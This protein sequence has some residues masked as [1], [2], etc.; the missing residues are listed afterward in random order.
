MIPTQNT[1]TPFRTIRHQVDFCVV[2]GGLSGLCA[3]VAAARHGVRVLLMQDR[4]ML[5]GNASSEIRMWVCGAQGENRQETGLVEE[6]MLENLYRNPDRNYSVWDSVLYELAFCQERLTLLLNCSCMD[7]KTQNGRILSVTGWQMTTQT[8]HTVEA[9]IF[10]DCSGDSVLAP[11]SG[12][13]YRCGREAAGEFGEDIAPVLA[14]GKTMGMSC[15]IQAREETRPSVFIPPKWAYQ[16]TKEDL[17]YRVPDMDE[18]N[19][20]FWYMELGGEDDAIADT[21]RVRDEL[22]KVAYGVWDYVKNAPE[23]RERNSNWRL[24]WVGMLPGKRESRRYVGDHILTQNDV[25]AGGRFEDLVAYGGWSMDDHDPAGIRS[26]GVPTVFH[27]APSPYGIPYRC[28]YSQNVENLMFAGRNISVTHTAMSSTRVMATCAL[29]GQA[30]GTAAAIAV[31]ERLTPRGVYEKRIGELQRQLM[32]DDCW[33]PGFVREIPA[34]TK[35]A[36]LVCSA[37]DARNLRSGIDRPVG[38]DENSAAVAKGEAIT[39]RFSE[40]AAV[41]RVRVVFNSDLNRST[42]PPQ[43]ARRHRNMLHNRPLNWPDVYVPKTLVR[44]FRIEGVEPDGT[45]R[46]LAEET[47]NYRRLRCY[48]VS[49]VFSAVRLIPLETWGAQQCRLFAF[50]AE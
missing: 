26:A 15:L 48:A 6:I 8:F 4:P 2:G 13:L 5:G 49:G 1:D 21:E 25:R 12:A 30:V 36:E 35:E 10:A 43:E 40:P 41:S 31:K 3:A 20:N 29:C 33:L 18:I 23:N 11:L 45:V 39:Y 46:V 34:L 44:I 27:P 9:A 24:D 37:P 19:E 38:T 7:C 42:L 17:P 47:N 14:D 32:D 28:L 50:E 16:Y 22:L